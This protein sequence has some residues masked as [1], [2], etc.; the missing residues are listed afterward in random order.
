MG[1]AVGFPRRDLSW[2]ATLA[3]GPHPRLKLLSAH[4][5]PYNA[6][7]LPTSSQYPTIARLLSPAATGRLPSLLAGAVRVARAAGLPLRLTELNSVSCG[8]RPG[9]S[10]AFATALWA[11][12]ALFEVLRAGV[13]G[14]NVHVRPDKIN[15]AFAITGHGLIARPLLYGLILFARTLGP[16]AACCRC[17]S[18]LS[19]GTT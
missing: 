10:D 19:A 16:D 14:V 8:G 2:L 15:G 6:C 11:P 13:A 3:R 5:Y 4:L 7:A 17:A 9:V 18:P 1:P 12:D